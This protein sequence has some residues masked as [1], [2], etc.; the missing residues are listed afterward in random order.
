M[1]ALE[2]AEEAAPSGRGTVLIVEDDEGIRSLL[3]AVAR[4]DGFD[5]RVAEDGAGAIKA[6]GDDGAEPDVI[7]LDLLMPRVDGFSV[8]DHLDRSRPHLL[9][10]VIILTA[11]GESSLRKCRQIDRVFCVRR[12]PLELADLRVQ[13]LHCAAAAHE[14]GAGRRQKER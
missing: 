3:V 11:A 10:S 8:L 5:C 14:R 13:M 6:L 2:A 9:S 12:K 7:L 1:H 4:H